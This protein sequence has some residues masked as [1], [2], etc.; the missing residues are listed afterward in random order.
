M[1]FS[2]KLC[3]IKDLTGLSQ[4]KLAQNLGVT[5]ATLNSW[6]NERS[7]P[8]SQ[9]AKRIDR[10]YQECAGVKET[11][12]D[13]LESK[14]AIIREKAKLDKNVL[15]FVLSNPDVRDQ[16]L[17]TLTYNTNRIEGSTLTEPQTAAILFDNVAFSNKSLIEQLEV[18]NHQAAFNYL[19]SHLAQTPIINEPLISKLHSMLMNGIRD[20][21]GLYRQ[22]AVRI[23]GADIP[24]ANYVKIPGLM[25]ELIEEIAHQNVDAIQHISL[26]HSRF[27][28]IHPFSDGNGRI[29]RLIIQAMA[30]RKN[31]PPA[32]IQQKRKRRYYAV[33]NKAQRSG[34]TRDLEEFLCDAFLEGIRLL[35]R[36]SA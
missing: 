17:L 22:H 31:L 14:K 35:K 16:F 5:F 12:G 32:I 28:K 4:E 6:I 7:E 33:L 13:P 15:N 29:G 10:L 25:A 19:L 23:V 9:A 1:K 24:T 34:E 20:D 36:N 18:K 26:I 3:L 8:R 21:A 30:L 2:E 27:E 11:K